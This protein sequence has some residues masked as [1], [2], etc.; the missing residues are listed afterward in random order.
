MYPVNIGVYGTTLLCLYAD[1]PYSLN[2][3]IRSRV[4]KERGQV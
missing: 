1:E 4:K 3:D 2:S